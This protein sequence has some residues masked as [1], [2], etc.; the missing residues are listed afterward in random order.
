M[1]LYLGPL[2]PFSR[3]A[4]VRSDCDP[5]VCKQGQ[6]GYLGISLLPGE[7]GGTREPAPNACSQTLMAW[8][9]GRHC[10][11]VMLLTEDT[12]QHTEA[13]PIESPRGGLS[14]QLCPGSGPLSFVLIDEVFLELLFSIFFR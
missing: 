13:I 12:P 5:R 2:L 3:K 4:E 1:S 6:Q 7:E 10:P 8:R 9:A 11:T 14:T